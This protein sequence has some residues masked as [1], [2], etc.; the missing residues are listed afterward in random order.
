M[1]SL[2]Y[3]LGRVVSIEQIVTWVSQF[4]VFSLLA[5]AAFFGVYGVFKWQQTKTPNKVV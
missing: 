2:S 1:V 4:G 3:F 5:I